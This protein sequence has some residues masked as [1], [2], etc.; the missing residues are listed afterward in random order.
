MVEKSCSENSPIDWKPSHDFFVGIDSDGCAFDTMEIKHKECFCPNTIKWWDLQSVSTLARQTAEYVNLYS[1]WRGANRWPALLKTLDLLRVRPEV[2]ARQV[3]IPQ[4][5]SIRAFITSDLPLSD[6]G[7]K[8][9]MTHNSDIDLER[10]LN[11][12]EG[13]NRSICE[14]VHGIPPFPF[15][16]ESLVMLSQKADC[17]VVSATPAEALKR[18]WE[19]HNVAQYMRMIAG[20]EMGSKKQQL[21]LAGRG[22]Y[23]HDHI[24]MIGDAWGDLEAARA[25]GSLFFPIL[26]NRAEHSWEVFFK[27]GIDRFFAGKFAG[28]YETELITEFENCLPVTSPW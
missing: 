5:D 18:E 22:N 2:Q 7:L 25:V 23:E 28:N 8:Q 12:T 20:Q 27:E 19:E 21:A 15:V 26:P 6:A 13:V 14:M 3:D 10:A 11:W 17:V 9:F 16:C 4:A 24:L 1:R